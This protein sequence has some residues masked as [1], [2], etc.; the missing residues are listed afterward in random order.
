M[1][2][3]L[4]TLA[5]SA[6]RVPSMELTCAPVPT[7]TKELIVRMISMNAKLAPPA[8]TM[9]YVSTLLDPSGATVPADSL[10]LA[11]R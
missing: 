9:A 8:N 7:D 4:A 2:P 1:L 10:V 5:P 6:I 11:A 3:I